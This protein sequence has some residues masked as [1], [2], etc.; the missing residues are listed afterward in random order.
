[1]AARLVLVPSPLAAPTSWD[2]VAERLARDRDVV[3]F[4][5]PEWS[6]LAPPYRVALAKAVVA[7]ACSQPAPVVVLHSAAGSLLGELEAAF[8]GLAG[9]VLVDAVLPHP[10]LSWFSTAPPA[11]AE[12]LQASAQGGAVPLWSEWFGDGVMRAVLPNQDD[13][14]RFVD[15]LRRTPLAFLEEPASPGRSTRSAYV[16]LSA[17]YDA[18]AAQAE[19]AGWPVRRIVA[20]HLAMVTSPEVV[21]DA[22]TAALM[23]LAL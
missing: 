21:A 7:R 22:I 4:H 2:R 20:S 19:R 12:H 8:G 10:G 17:A 3:S 23:D 11:L 13:R 5:T 14:A 9:A 6:Q 18:E 15:A 16:R 1:M